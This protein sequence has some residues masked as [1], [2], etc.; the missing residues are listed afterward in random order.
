MRKKRENDFRFKRSRKQR[1][2]CIYFNI[3]QF[4]KCKKNNQ[5]MTSANPGL[6]SIDYKR[7]G[8]PTSELFKIKDSRIVI[9]NEF[10]NVHINIEAF[11]TL[12]S[13]GF[14]QMETRTLYGEPINFI[15]KF[16]MFIV[17]NNDPQISEDRAILDRIKIIDF[18]ARFVDDPTLCNPVKHIYERDLYITEKIL[19]NENEKSGILNWLISG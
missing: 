2:I 15:P 17:T 10:G 12:T 5:F 18:K 7:A 8:V 9:F 1:E 4:V 13:G 16:K 19:N 3:G 11:K 6:L 14:D